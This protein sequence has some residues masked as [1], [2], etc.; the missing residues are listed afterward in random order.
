[1]LAWLQ[2]NGCL[3]LLITTRS[4]ASQQGCGWT[5]SF[6]EYLY[7]KFTEGA[8]HFL[9]VPLCDRLE[10]K[11]KVKV[12]PLPPFQ[13]IMLGYTLLD[14]ALRKLR[15][16]RSLVEAEKPRYDPFSPL[17][18]A[19]CTTSAAQIDAV[20]AWQLS[21]SG[22]TPLNHIRAMEEFAREHHDR[23]IQYRKDVLVLGEV[24]TGVRT[25]Y[26]DAAFATAQRSLSI[27][28]ANS[29]EARGS[30]YD[31]QRGSIPSRASRRST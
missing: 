30:S 3:T 11:K 23:V 12:S 27:N 10:E 17:S 1:M 21:A 28:S 18:V 31:L 24:T 5:I 19:S 8:T 26:H 15:Q 16:S 14:D 6:N 22:F 9:N 25:N 2:S 29:D 20:F 13:K 4:F 7:Q